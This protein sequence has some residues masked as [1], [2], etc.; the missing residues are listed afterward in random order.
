MMF[1]TCTVTIFSPIYFATHLLLSPTHPDQSQIS[2]SLSDLQALPVSI[3][4]SYL[5]PTIGLILSLCFGGPTALYSFIAIWQFFPVYQSALHP[6]IRSKLASRIQQKSKKMEDGNGAYRTELGTFYRFVLALSVGSHLLLIGAA[7]ASSQIAQLPPISLTNIL[8]PTSLT[9]PPTLAL[10]G[11]P[12]SAAA[13]KKIVMAFL[14][15]DIYCASTALSIWASVLAA[16]DARG[17]IAAVTVADALFWAMV[18]GP[19]APAAVMLR[20]RDMEVLR[21]GV[22]EQVVSE[23]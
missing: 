17:S 2:V 7:F 1:Q 9:K 20:Q 13:S 15:W 19:V 18:G 22:A 10:Y 14:R 11:P 8:A 6:Y 4:A 12:I 3:T 23:K 5:I 21:K 16:R